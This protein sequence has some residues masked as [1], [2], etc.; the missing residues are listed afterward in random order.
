MFTAVPDLLHAVR[1]LTKAR[2][3]T[4]VSVMSLG[5]GMGVVI[6]IMLVSRMLMG[7][8]AGVDDD[9][10]AELVMRPIGALRAQV[11]SAIIDAWSYPDYLD[12]R[13]A[14]STRMSITG[15]AR[16]AALVRL[17]NQAA[18]APAPAMF[19]SSNYFSTVGVAL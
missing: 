1:T 17:P 19:V 13:E 9:R 15:W 5:L 7:T 11:G 2:A 16:G 12:V 10:L 6:L 8:P 18:A 4:A 14:A 3:F